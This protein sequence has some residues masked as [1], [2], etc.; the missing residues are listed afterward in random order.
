MASSELNF[1][2]SISGGPDPLSV[3]E[4]CLLEFVAKLLALH[5]GDGK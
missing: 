5:L 4:E 3:T 2:L 1:A